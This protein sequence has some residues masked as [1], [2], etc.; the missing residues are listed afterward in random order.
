M[1]FIKE[2]KIFS[3][4]ALVFIISSILFLGPMLLIGLGAP[5]WIMGVG[6]FTVA[7]APNIAA[8]IVLGLFGGW[9]EIK[10]LLAKFVQWDFKIELYLIPVFLPMIVVIAI[11]WVYDIVFNERN[12][13]VFHS[14][15]GFYSI[16]FMTVNHLFRGP[17]G[18]EGGWRG[19]L[20]PQ[21]L[22]K[23]SLIIATLY[24]GLVWTVWH[25]PYWFFLTNGLFPDD[26]NRAYLM[27]FSLAWV[28]FPMSLI[29]GW[30][31]TKSKGSLIPAVLFHFFWNFSNEFI[32]IPKDYHYFGLAVVYTFIAVILIIVNREYLFSKYNF[33]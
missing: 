11:G 7:W 5:E 12:H 26:P 21:Y 22:Q 17:L 23:H 28:I 18:E 4:I 20:L 2:K 30:L 15:W 14:N 9:S 8:V 25:F 6:E 1:K 24:V 19:F 33:S 29:M 32:D 3:F 16:L 31:Y 27:F 10:K 13:G